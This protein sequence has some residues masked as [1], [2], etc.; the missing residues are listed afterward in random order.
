VG[1]G[2]RGFGGVRLR[3][4]RR[5]G[6]FRDSGFGRDIFR[7][8]RALRLQETQLA[9]SAV[10]GALQATFI[11]AQVVKG[12][13]VVA[14]RVGDAVKGLRMD[15]P[16]GDLRFSV[17][18]LEEL[19]FAM[20]EARQAEVGQRD[21]FDERILAA[22]LGIVFGEKVLVD[23]EE[24]F[25]GLAFDEAFGEEAVDEVVAAGTSLSFRV[26]GPVERR[27]FSAANS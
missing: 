1:R 17:F 5:G 18:A 15:G 3:F 27:A 20:G 21:A 12:L 8:A 6:S 24:F 25:P 11:E 7:L 22:G 2:R 19:S 13:H 23:G 16:G 26:R 9:D 4:R 14:E 10:K